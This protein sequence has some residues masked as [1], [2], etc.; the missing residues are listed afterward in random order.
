MISKAV[1]WISALVFG[2]FCVIYTIVFRNYK[3]AIENHKK[4]TDL[5]NDPKVRVAHG[6]KANQ[7]IKAAQ[8]ESD[9]EK[10]P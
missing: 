10:V 7:L 3:L 6:E 5:F 4:L 8:V 1:E 2:G 9:N